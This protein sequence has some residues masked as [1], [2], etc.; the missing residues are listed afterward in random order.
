MRVGLWYIK[1]IGSSRAFIFCPICWPSKQKNFPENFRK[2]EKKLF[3][4]ETDF[5]HVRWW[6][7]FPAQMALKLRKNPKNQKKNFSSE[8][9]F[10]HVKKIFS[11]NLPKYLEKL[12]WC[13]VWQNHFVNKKLIKSKDAKNKLALKSEMKGSLLFG[14]FDSA[15]F[16]FD[17]SPCMKS[18]VTKPLC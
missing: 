10:E 15:N 9:N 14:F 4:P 8:M 13:H 5:E 1:M 18:C 7:D 6:G 11:T 2:F 3:F 12:G 16:F 17:R